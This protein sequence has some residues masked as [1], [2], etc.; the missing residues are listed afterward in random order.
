MEFNF[1]GYISRHTL[2]NMHRSFISRLVAQLVCRGGNNCVFILQ[3]CLWGFPESFLTNLCGSMLIL[4]IRYHESWQKIVGKFSIQFIYFQKC[5][6][7]KIPI[8]CDPFEF[9]HYTYNSVRKYFFSFYVNKRIIKKT[10][11]NIHI[12]KKHLNVKFFKI[13]MS[14]NLSS[15]LL[16]E[17]LEIIF[18]HHLLVRWI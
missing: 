14:E 10:D 4:I 1:I 11:E 9:Y 3:L 15:L 5:K 8:I 16:N 6:Y 13:K 18:I 17:G 7:T 12:E 2:L